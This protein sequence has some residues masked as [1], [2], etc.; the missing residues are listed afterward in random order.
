VNRTVS[1]ARLIATAF[2]ASR[3]I[4]PAP[5]LFLVRIRFGVYSVL[6]RMGVAL[7]WARLEDEAARRALAG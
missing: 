1:Q 7:D 4:V 2:P 5:L 3:R 6:S